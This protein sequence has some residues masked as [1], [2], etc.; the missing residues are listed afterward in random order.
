MR[1]DCEAAGIRLQLVNPGFIATPMTEGRRFPMPFLLTVEEGARRIV[2]GHAVDRREVAL[3]VGFARGIR[4]RQAGNGGG[5]F[6][7]HGMGRRGTRPIADIRRLAHD[8]RF[9]RALATQALDQGRHRIAAI[10][11]LDD[12]AETQTVGLEFLFARVASQG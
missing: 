4:E 8:L 10:A 7:R 9:K 6:H 12:I 1:F 2:D 5:A 3:L 11:G